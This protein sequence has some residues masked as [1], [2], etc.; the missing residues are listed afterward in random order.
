MIPSNT[1]QVT[2]NGAILKGWVEN[3][4]GV[5]KGDQRQFGILNMKEYRYLVFYLQKDFRQEGELWIMEEETKEA[6]SRVR[7][8]FS[9]EER[10]RF[11]N[12][13]SHHR[14]LSTALIDLILTSSDR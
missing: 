12:E 1:M 5:L 8:M 2:P 7:T 3:R 10:I 4:L 14:H 11:Q 9:D 13:V 6:L